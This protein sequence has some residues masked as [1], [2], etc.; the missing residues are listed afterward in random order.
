MTEV[1]VTREH[2]Y[3]VL[4]SR[5]WLSEAP[6][7]YQEWA[8]TGVN[9]CSAYAGSAASFVMESFEREAR[10]DAEAE[11]RGAQKERLRM[12]AW[13]NKRIE[14]GRQDGVPM[15]KAVQA[16]WIIR[17]AFANGEHGK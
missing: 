7:L 3:R 9:K 12:L 11:E 15:T 1:K 4:H 13:L 8:E 17:D 10:I 16:A 2:R 5:G 14:E 6:E